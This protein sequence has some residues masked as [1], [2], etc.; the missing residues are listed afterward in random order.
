[1]LG[2]SWAAESATQ[3]VVPAAMPKHFD[4]GQKLEGN[5]RSLE[6]NVALPCGIVQKGK[7]AVPSD[8]VKAG[9][10]YRKDLEQYALMRATR[11][12]TFANGSL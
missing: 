12:G 6:P 11:S 10:S 1:M 8:V 7:V 4:Q 9:C 5:G 3:G 2:S